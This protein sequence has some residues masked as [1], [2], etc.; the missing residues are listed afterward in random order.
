MSLH[1]KRLVR[2]IFDKMD[3]SMGYV[4]HD[5]VSRHH[6]PPTACLLSPIAQGSAPASPSTHKAEDVHSTLSYMH[7]VSSMPGCVTW[8]AF[9]DYY[10]CISLAIADDRAFESF[11]R[12]SWFIP[13][14]FY[15]PGK[16]SPSPTAVHELE[17]ADLRSRPVTPLTLKVTVTSTSGQQEEM[18]VYDELGA[19]RYSLPSMQRHVSAKGVRDVAQITW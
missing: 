14:L 16:L 12:S 18:E 9:L 2:A 10:R 6:R 7:S 1:R 15:S 11:L 8:S 19:M 13:G 3:T 4:S 5:D 17:E